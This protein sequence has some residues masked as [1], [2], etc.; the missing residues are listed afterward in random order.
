MTEFDSVKVINVGKDFC[1]FPLGRYES[2]GGF[3]GEEFRR[4]VLI[5]ALQKHLK[6]VV[7]LDDVTYGLDSSF[8]EE[9]FGG[10][11][12]HKIYT[13]DQLMERLIIISNSVPSYV[14]EIFEYI[15][16]AEPGDI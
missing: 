4:S 15:N 7:N 6:V 5:P 11:V 12:R 2:D 16:N 3:S 1:E 14:E 9:A 10:L 13:C 8:L